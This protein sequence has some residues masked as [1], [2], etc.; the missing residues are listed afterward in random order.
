MRIK[1]LSIHPQNTLLIKKIVYLLLFL[2]LLLVSANLLQIFLAAHATQRIIIGAF[3]TTLIILYLLL[4]NIFFSLPR[5][6]FKGVDV[7]AALKESINLAVGPSPWYVATFPELKAGFK[8]KFEWR[9]L[10][11][12]GKYSFLV[13]LA[14]LQETGKVKLVLNSYVRPFLLEPG[15]LGLWYVQKGTLILDCLSVADLP[16]FSLEELPA[17]FKGSAAAYFSLGLPLARVAIPLSLREGVHEI[18]FPDEFTSL[19]ELLVVV[20]SVG[21]NYAYAVM[22]LE[23]A[24]SQVKV[25]PQKW[26]TKEKFDL[27]YEWITRV[28]RDPKTGKMY[29][30]GIRI[31]IFELT[32]DGTQ[33]ARWIGNSGH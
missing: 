20:P 16:S 6:F 27:G 14:N 3:I 17:D 12:K 7:S 29:G 10:G 5:H 31:G 2:A 24:A 33:I 30:D 13:A 15:W 4:R 23:P 19:D 21:G 32:D 18:R 11:E 9:H 26:F 28:T 22:A 25:Y 8:H 1:F